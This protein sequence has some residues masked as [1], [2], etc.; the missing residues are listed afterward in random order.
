VIE[1]R[2]TFRGVWGPRVLAL[3]AL[4][5]SLGASSRARA[6]GEAESEPRSRPESQ[7]AS[8]D[9]G[10]VE[11]GETRFSTFVDYVIGI[12]KTTAVDSLPPTSASVNPV[13][14]VDADPVFTNSFLFGLG[15]E[16]IKNLGFGVR[17]PL[18]IGTISPDGYQG[19]TLSVFGNIELEGE[20]KVHLSETLAMAYSLGVALP[21][22][23]GT[24]VPDTS[25]G[26][27]ANVNQGSYD[28]YSLSYAAGASRGFEEN[29]LFFSDRLGI[30]PKVSLEYHPAG[31]FRFEPYAKVEN[32]ISIAND[33]ST[34]YIGELLLVAQASYLIGKYVEP[35]L[36]LWTTIAYA[37]DSDGS[38]GVVEPEARFHVG[39]L[40][41]YLGVIVPFAG[42]ISKDPSHFVGIRLGAALAF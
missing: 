37:G 31:G 17:L 30:I 33:G 22:A 15:Y 8:E 14:Q 28:S 5:A 35:G 7:P 38:A 10:S 12:G 9:E 16:P 21:T 39:A 25:A 11:E 41:P 29:A 6:N 42:P 24:R 36:R 18:T 3:A 32:L 27:P 2:S 13:N 40:T 34:K 20:Y 4:A 26:L 19:R 23:I 1:P